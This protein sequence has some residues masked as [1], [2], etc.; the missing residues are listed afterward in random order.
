[1]TK[2]AIPPTNGKQVTSRDIS[3][4]DLVVRQWGAEWSKPD[5]VYRFSNGVEKDSTDMT[6]NGYYTR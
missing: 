3:W 4:K 5:K 1:M 2:P 6:N